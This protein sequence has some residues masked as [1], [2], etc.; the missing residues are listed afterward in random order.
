MK[1][2]VS[3]LRDAQFKSGGLRSFFEYRDLGIKDATGGKVLA[4]I[5]RA[6]EGAQ[7]VTGAHYHQL[8]FQMFYVQ[9]LDR[10]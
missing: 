2:S 4:H 8:E 5:I 1:F 7:G 3:H 6:R 9:G 10:I